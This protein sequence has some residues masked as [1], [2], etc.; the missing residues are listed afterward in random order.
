M[1][2]F[3]NRFFPS[4]TAEETIRPVANQSRLGGD[5]LVSVDHAWRDGRLL[6]SIVPDQNIEGFLVGLEE[7][8][9]RTRAEDENLVAAE[10]Q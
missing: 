2:D 10:S 5:V 1:A 3:V 9:G 4:R 6:F 7:F 8:T